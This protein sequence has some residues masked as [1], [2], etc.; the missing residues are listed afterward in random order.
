MKTLRIASRKTN[1]RQIG[2]RVVANQPGVERVAFLGDRTHT[3]PPANDVA[4]CER[5]AVGCDDE[6]RALP[7]LLFGWMLAN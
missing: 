5:K 4:V 6:A 1:Q 2:R 3:L 7:R